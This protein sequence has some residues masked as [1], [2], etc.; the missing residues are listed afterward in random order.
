MTF[1]T[2]PPPSENLYVRRLVEGGVLGLVAL[3]VFLGLLLKESYARSANATAQT[4]RL[5]LRGAVVALAIQSF[6][7]DTLMFPQW[8]AIFY[9]IVGAAGAALA[10]DEPA[11][12]PRLL[13]HTR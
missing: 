9:L 1:S 12:F 10:L 3:L 5:A 11:L 13:D 7:A 2:A 4:W 8:A 6:F